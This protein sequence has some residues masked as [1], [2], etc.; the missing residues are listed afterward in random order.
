MLTT[1]SSQPYFGDILAALGSVLV[2]VN[3]ITELRART[4]ALTSA[5]VCELIRLHPVTL[6]DWTRSS[7][8]PAYRVGREYR[9]DPSKIADWLQEREICPRL[10]P[11]QKRLPTHQAMLTKKA[12]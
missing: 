3:L 10:E 6:R 11:C 4:K 7:R 1:R 2:I 8:I 5:E 12:A 9:Y